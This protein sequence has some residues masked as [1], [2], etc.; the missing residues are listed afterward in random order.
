M[1]RDCRNW[2]WQLVNAKGKV[3]GWEQ[4]QV[5]V[6]QDIRAELRTLN[7]LLSCDRFMSMP[8]TLA[9]LDQLVATALARKKGKH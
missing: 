7:E 8:S 5:A 9:H 3:N 4:A 2:S 6:L 1:S